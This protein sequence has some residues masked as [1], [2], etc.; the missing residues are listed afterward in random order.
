MKYLSV[1]LIFIF[2][3]TK[4]ESSQM[5]YEDI[6]RHSLETNIVSLPQG[7]FLAAGAH[8][9]GSL[10]TRDFCFSVP[11]LL[12]LKKYSLVKNHLSYLVN[13]R[14]H[15]GLVPIYADSINPMFRVIT[16]SINQF[17]GS[18]IRYKIKKDIKPYYNA[19]GKYPTIDA[20]VL[21]LKAAYEYYQATG[22]EKWWQ[23]NQNAFL[24][25]YNYYKKFLND[26][27]I[28]QGAYSDW[29]DSSKRQGKTFFTNLLFLDVSGSFH[30]LSKLELDL[31]TKKI[32]EVFYNQKTGLY[33]SVE[34]EPY[35]S[36]DGI[37]WALDKNLMPMSD[38]LY[39]RLKQHPLWNKY[40]MPGFATYPSYPKEW[41]APHVK[42]IGLNEYHGNLSWS[43]L[44]AYS[45]IV[46]F[47]Y[48]DVQ[49][50][51]R[52]S[53]KL[54]EIILRDKNVA[55]VYHSD[56][57]YLP[58]HSRLYQS[59]APFSWGASFVIELLKVQDRIF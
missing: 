44:M 36:I 56:D 53:S 59:E 42:L 29:Q 17:L 46:A 28:S 27:L 16:G 2:L 39:E 58:F 25:I 48:G 5:N 11:G 12:T 35:I 52:I 51:L 57:S 20:N 4:A 55:E 32:H 19:T 18:K 15:D 13:N 6:A 10:W 54:E 26:G 37:L 47:K 50:S 3:L 34:G 24:E 40:A 41:I 31:L 8:Q 43:W 9:F 45:S 7:E 49:E 22:D 14:R 30:F 23:A 38:L 1:I 33:R 21:V